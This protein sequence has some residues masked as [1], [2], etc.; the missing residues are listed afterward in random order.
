MSGSRKRD[1]LNF[2]ALDARN[3]L[4]PVLS[5]WSRLVAERL[6]TAV[7]HRSVVHLADFLLLHL[8]WLTAHSSAADF[9]EEIEGLHTEL[10]RAIDPDAG[11]RPPPA[12]ECVVDTCTG[13]I[14]ASPKSTGKAGTRSISCSAGHAWEM[15][16]WLTL[17]YLMD[18]RRKDAA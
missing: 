17:R 8:E 7:P 9:A 11:D 1:H 10:L 14:N 3:D 15:R 2:A 13:T 6:G 5:S 4:I 16:E 18:R 12:T